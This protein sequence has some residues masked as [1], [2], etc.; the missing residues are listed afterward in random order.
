MGRRNCVGA[1]CRGYSAVDFERTR[2]TRLV[3][4]HAHPGGRKWKGYKVGFII[5]LLTQILSS[6]VGDTQPIV[7]MAILAL[8]L[9]FNN[10]FKASAGPGETREYNCYLYYLK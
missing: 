10:P 4:L 1:F 8:I 5:D 3:P 2:C 6:F 7:M 9:P